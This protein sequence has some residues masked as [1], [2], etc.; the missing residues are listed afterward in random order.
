M[1]LSQPML[2]A[3][4]PPASPAPTL[5][6]DGHAALDA[7]RCLSR[8]ASPA[9][10]AAMAS[11]PP[12]LG[13]AGTPEGFG[14][15]SD[16]QANAPGSASL[17]SG[18]SK[19][20]P[21]AGSPAGSGPDG[22]LVA[23]IDTP[24]SLAGTV[25]GEN[26]S[27][28][29]YDSAVESP[30]SST[31]AAPPPMAVS[32]SLSVASAVNGRSVVAS[33]LERAGGGVEG[34]QVDG[35]AIEAAAVADEGGEG[36]ASPS[37]VP[38]D[39]SYIEDDEAPAGPL[40]EVAFGD[41]SA[42]LAPAVPLTEAAPG[43][44]STEVASI[45]AS[46]E[47]ASAGGDAVDDVVS[48]SEGQ[49]RASSRRPSPGAE[50]GA[51]AAE[52]VVNCTTSDP[53]AVGDAVVEDLSGHGSFSSGHV[54]PGEGTMNG[55]P[56][57]VA[58]EAAKVYAAEGGA[59]AVD[60]SASVSGV[61]A[62]DD[63]LQP[64]DV[65]PDNVWDG[66]VNDEEEEEDM[67]EE[68]LEKKEEGRESTIAGTEPLANEGAAM[69]PAE[70]IAKQTHG[71]EVVESDGGSDDEGQGLEEL[72]ARALSKQD[73]N[74]DSPVP[75]PADRSEDPALDEASPEPLGDGEIFSAELEGQQQGVHPKPLGDALTPPQQ[76][77]KGLT[78]VD[79]KRPGP[80]DDPPTATPSEQQQQQ[81][82]AKDS[83]GF[84]VP[85]HWPGGGGAQP[86]DSSA[87]GGGEGKARGQEVGG[88]APPEQAGKTARLSGTAIGK[89][90]SVPEGAAR[91]IVEKGHM[92]PVV[93]AV[94]ELLLRE[95]L[96][97]AVEDMVPPCGAP[98]EEAAEQEL[99]EF[100]LPL[101]P[102]GVRHPHPAPQPPPPHPRCPPPPQPSPHPPPSHPAPHP[103]RPP[104]ALPKIPH[105][106]TATT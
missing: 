54:T 24:A 76:Q 84:V 87:P 49:R 25:P 20:L 7:V 100:G 27:V 21:A 13:S 15:R 19:Q 92:E 44:E 79:V 68:C 16:R 80:T 69:S 86:L 104:P 61:K 67:V 34:S 94:V 77:Q 46:A 74:D 106:C 98:L 12:T 88:Q 75:S 56:N 82:Q 35:P 14:L 26:L 8:S 85:A 73:M 89:A 103:S 47:V 42:E 58:T 2:A 32:S 71:E 101:H 3:T 63:V 10:S 93:D 90:S 30:S 4:P 64:C 45:D 52:D 5:I 102:E 18:G 51:A 17:A 40:T 9:S 22:R 70:V 62:V 41:A 91:A 37:S 96:Q 57:A 6:V 29:L 97:A 39:M 33:S 38:T 50:E 66:E 55:E 65:G 59:V 31:A 23:Q 1:L 105:P 99:D 28:R 78:A 83:D 72:I 36:S 11:P 60:P 43:Y 81:Q 95:L 53:D 48:L